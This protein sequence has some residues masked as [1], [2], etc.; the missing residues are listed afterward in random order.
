MWRLIGRAMFAFLELQPSFVLYHNLPGF[1]QI[2]FYFITSQ[3]NT[4]YT[5]KKERNSNKI[6]EICAFSPFP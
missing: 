6:M 2:L 5:N 3:K 4:I 1:C